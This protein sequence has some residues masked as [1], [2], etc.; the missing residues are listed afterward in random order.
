LELALA[1]VRLADQEARARRERGVRVA[2]GNLPEAVARVLE[3]LAIEIRF[4]LRVQLVGRQDRDRRRAQERRHGA[5]GH[6]CKQAG[7]SEIDE[8]TTRFGHRNGCYIY[9]S[10]AKKNPLTSP[11]LA[12]IYAAYMAFPDM[13]R[14]RQT[15]P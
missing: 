12:G 15:F 3:A 7:E 6:H 1:E 5:A 11:G 2:L 10:P 4:A 9:H 13:L 8:G 14:V